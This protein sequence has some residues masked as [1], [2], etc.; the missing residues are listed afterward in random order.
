MKKIKRKASVR[1][2]VAAMQALDLDSIPPQKRQIAVMA[3]YLKVATQDM[4]PVERSKIFAGFA[5]RVAESNNSPS[6]IELLARVEP[7]S[8]PKS[9][10]EQRFL[11]IL[12]RKLD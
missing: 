12:T 3:Q 8:G 4:D 5:K 11:D 6:C 10:Q 1:D 2:M 9:E 7:P